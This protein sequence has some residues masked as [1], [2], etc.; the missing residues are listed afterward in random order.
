MCK[1]TLFLFITFRYGLLKNI[2]VPNVRFTIIF[3]FRLQFDLQRQCEK[4]IKKI[5]DNLYK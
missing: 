1:T 4:L 3:I 2:Q 5:V